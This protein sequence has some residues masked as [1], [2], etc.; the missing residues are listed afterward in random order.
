MSTSYGR[1]VPGRRWYR[2]AAAIAAAVILVSAGIFAGALLTRGS[3]D[4][5]PDTALASPSDTT[6]NSP[7]ATVTRP[8]SSPTS[9]PT[10]QR[11][12]CPTAVPRRFGYQPLWPFTSQSDVAIWQSAYRKNGSQP[13]H[14]DA[15]QTAL[16][17]TTGYLGFSEIDKVVG[18]TIRGDHAWISVGFTVED[19]DRPYVSAVIHLVKY[20]ADRDAPWEVVGTK[21]GDFTLTTPKYGARMSSPVQ[22]G[23]RITG[24][25]ESILVE[26]RQ[27]ASE[28]PLGVS[29]AV[30]AGGEKQPWKATVSF[31]GASDPALTV[32]ARTGGHMKDVERFAITAIRV[33]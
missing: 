17:F 26:I 18:R 24:V 22:V 5:S 6:A 31:R 12:N 16:T 9:C 4:Q 11:T 27:P 10:S 1:P 25:D 3:D 28:D 20:G 23:G 2:M 33:G 29:Q 30:M 21:D 7:S 32:V 19:M 14:L 15:D 8:R 13:W